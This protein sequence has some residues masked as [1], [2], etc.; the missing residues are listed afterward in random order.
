LLSSDLPS[1][2]SLSDAAAAVGSAHAALEIVDSVWLDY[3]FTLADNTADGSSAAAVVIGPDLHSRD[4]L[5]RI[6]VDLFL[7]ESHVGAGRG[8][9]ALGHPLQA[10]C[11]L[12][13]ALSQHEEAVHAG[14]I[15]ITGGLT[16]AIPIGPG[17]VIRA[18]FGDGVQV[19]TCFPDWADHAY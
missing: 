2:C 12:A 11:W 3:Q 18:D 14:D 5:D 1:D 9:D 8:A 17:D 6:D 13:Q 19:A 15:V 10:L 7:N 4:D 16:S